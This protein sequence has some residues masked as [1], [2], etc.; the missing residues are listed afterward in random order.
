M[1]F[2]NAKKKKLQQIIN[3]S[4]YVLFSYFF[5]KN[6]SLNILTIFSSVKYEIP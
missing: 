1:D 5:S 6:S 2:I 3:Q 4:I